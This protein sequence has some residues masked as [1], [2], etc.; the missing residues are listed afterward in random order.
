MN[1]PK[2]S[3]PCPLQRDMLR[4]NNNRYKKNGET[5]S[6][7]IY[8]K[9]YFAIRLLVKQVFCAGLKR[10]NRIKHRNKKGHQA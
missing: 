10:M 1:L 9:M 5:K 4:Q 8:I 6:F 7:A 2:I 3:S